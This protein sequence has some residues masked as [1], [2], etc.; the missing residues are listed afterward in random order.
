M[1]DFEERKQAI[2]AKHERNRRRPIPP[3]FRNLVEGMLVGDGVQPREYLQDLDDSIS[4]YLRIADA[5]NVSGPDATPATVHS[6]GRRMYRKC[7]ERRMSLV[8]FVTIRILTAKHIMN[9]SFSPRPPIHWAKTCEAWNEANHDYM[10]PAVLRVEF[11][12]AIAD[13]DFRQ[14][15]FKYWEG[16]FA[17]ALQLGVDLDSAGEEGW[18]LA[19]VLDER[20]YIRR[21]EED[22]REANEDWLEQVSYR[23]AYP[24]EIGKKRQQLERLKGIK[25]R[26]ARK[27]EAELRRSIRLTEDVHRARMEVM[28]SGPAATMDALDKLGFLSWEMYLSLGSKDDLEVLLGMRH[29]HAHRFKSTSVTP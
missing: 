20:D 2:W 3:R 25:G 5:A 9:R 10:S 29:R 13:P 17:E 11:Q 28:K 21:L 23:A 8:Y 14:E 16:L 26:E 27:R 1:K 24:K 19:V 7:L 15:F 6:D 12:R 22:L 4:D 18:S